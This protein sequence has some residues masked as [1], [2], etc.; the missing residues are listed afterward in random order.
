MPLTRRFFDTARLA[1]GAPETL[2]PG[3]P[4]RLRAMNVTKD[5]K[6]EE[7]LAAVHRARENREWLILMFH[8]LVDQPEW[9][10]QYSI[11]DFRR[12][13]Q[14]IDDEGIAVWPV[15]QVWDD[16]RAG[17][18][19]P[20]APDSPA[21]RSAAVDSAPWPRP[22]GFPAGRRRRGRSASRRASPTCP[23][24][25]AARIACASRAS[26]SARARGEIGGVDDLLYRQALPE[27]LA[28]GVN[29][30]DTALSDRMQ[31]SE[32]ALGVALARAL[33]E[34]VAARDEIVVVTKGGPAHARPRSGAQHRRS[35]PQSDRHATSRR[36]SSRRSASQA[37]CCASSRR[38]CATR[39]SAAGAI[40]GSRR[41]TSGAS[42][43]PSSRCGNSAARSSST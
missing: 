13:L 5:T 10:T 26:G 17:A 7:V 12:V 19:A 34:G 3:D 41:S 21:A 36:G 20:R 29:L 18:K 8:W 42:S 28:G 11:V 25:S 32:R 22:I 39:S 40:C 23:A 38:S 2:P 30:F 33:R 31:T 15:S 6:P 9:L 14:G 1:S 43:S 27:L 16:V 37:A 4:Y 24:T 35:A